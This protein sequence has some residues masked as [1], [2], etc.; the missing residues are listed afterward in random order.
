MRTRAETAAVMRCFG[1]WQCHAREAARLCLV[2]QTVLRRRDP[3]TLCRVRVPFYIVRGACRLVFDA[4]AL[5]EY[6]LRTGDFRDPVSRT[7]L[8]ELD[9]SRL[10]RANGVARRQLCDR[11]EALEAER[12]RSLGEAELVTAI[13]REI[14]GYLEQ[15]G[16]P[17]VPDL[18]ASR[19]SSYIV[20]SYRNLV[21]LDPARSEQHARGWFETIKDSPD[22]TECPWMLVHAHQTLEM[23]VR[24][25]SSR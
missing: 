7:S 21:A 16:D 10:G 3:I 15:L 11:R 9:L 2:L 1:G 22:Y 14:D 4:H 18:A 5:Y 19:L 23:V 20:Q 25:L 8:T 6:I 13:E 24:W 12:R 17:E